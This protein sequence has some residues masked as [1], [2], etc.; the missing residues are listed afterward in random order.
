MFEWFDQTEAR[1]V[2]LFAGFVLLLVLGLIT[3]DIVFAAL[4]WGAPEPNTAAPTVN[5]ITASPCQP[6]PDGTQVCDIPPPS[7]PH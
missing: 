5:Q 1:F 6:M 7:I 2:K 3:V 4:G